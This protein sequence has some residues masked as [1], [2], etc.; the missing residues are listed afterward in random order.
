M[1]TI[2]EARLKEDLTQTKVAEM[3]GMSRPTYIKW[4]RGEADEIKLSKVNELSKLLGLS[5]IK[6]IQQQKGFKHG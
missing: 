2:K 1:T 6:I 5:P 4:E 3:L